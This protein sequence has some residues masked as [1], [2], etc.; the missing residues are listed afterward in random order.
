MRKVSK[1]GKDNINSNNKKYAEI[2]DRQLNITLRVPSMKEKP[3]KLM[4]FLKERVLFENKR[5]WLMS[6]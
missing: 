5:E 3:K 4:K 1:I 6:P 2:R